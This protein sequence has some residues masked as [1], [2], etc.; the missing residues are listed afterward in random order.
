MPELVYIP[1]DLSKSMTSKNASKYNEDNICSI[2]FEE[3]SKQY[4]VR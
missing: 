4:K 2:C 1:T 3:F